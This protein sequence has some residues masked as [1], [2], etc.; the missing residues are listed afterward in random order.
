MVMAT[1]KALWA[2]GMTQNTLHDLDSSHINF[3]IRYILR[4][5]KA[6]IAI[7]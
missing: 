6:H 2:Y 3:L 5:K 7:E 1:F 4:I